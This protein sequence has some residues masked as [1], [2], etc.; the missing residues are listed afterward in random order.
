MAIN[1][2][3]TIELST[4]GNGIATAFLF[5]RLRILFSTTRI[6][7]DIIKHTLQMKTILENVRIR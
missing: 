5:P 4:A 7:A 1:P 3:T 6:M 2:S